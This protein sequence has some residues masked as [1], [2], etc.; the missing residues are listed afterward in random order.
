MDLATWTMINVVADERFAGDVNAA[1][2]EICIAGLD[3]EQIKEI[4]DSA[5]SKR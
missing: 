1:V 2:E 3:T 5:Q 4:L